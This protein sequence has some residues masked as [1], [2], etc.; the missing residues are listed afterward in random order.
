MTNGVLIDLEKDSS[1]LTKNLPLKQLFLLSIMKGTYQFFDKDGTTYCI[2]KDNLIYNL[3]R[4]CHSPFIKKMS[5][6]KNIVIINS[7]GCADDIRLDRS[8]VELAELTDISHVE[9]LGGTFMYY[10]Q[11]LSRDE[12][13]YITN[14]G[15]I[16]DKVCDN[17]DG[18][19]CSFSTCPYKSFCKYYSK[20][21]ARFIFME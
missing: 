7:N 6:K 1:L 14:P 13:C 11:Y 3:P 15:Y 4:I 10:L 5:K 17:G 8:L 20:K 18:N 19:S 2:R 9:D 12:S 16:L 21:D